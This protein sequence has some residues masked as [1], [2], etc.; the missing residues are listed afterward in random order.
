MQVQV[1]LQV[2]E[3]VI[4]TLSNTSSLDNRLLNTNPGGFSVLRLS[5]FQLAT[6]DEILEAKT[7]FKKQLT[8]D[9]AMR[10]KKSCGLDEP[11]SAR[12]V[13]VF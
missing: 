1:S 13:V 5:H 6:A 7:Y 2:I 10:Y 4:E 8:N 9:E 12:L 11:I 3:T